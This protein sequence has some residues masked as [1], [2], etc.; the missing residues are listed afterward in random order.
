M[1]LGAKEIVEQKHEFYENC[2]GDTLYVSGVN[3]FRPVI[4]TLL[5][6]FWIKFGINLDVI[7]WSLCEL[8]EKK[9][10]AVKNPALT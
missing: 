4:S 8:L 3:E 5:H 6:R 1:K 10:G 7:T 2:L 9:S